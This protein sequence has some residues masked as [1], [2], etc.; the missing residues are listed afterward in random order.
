MQKV[1]SI[2]KIKKYIEK[3]KF[4][5]DPS[6]AKSYNKKIKSK[7]I[8]L[9]IVGTITPP[10]GRG[11]FYT[12]PSNKMYKRIDLAL[13]NGT[14]LENDVN[15]LGCLVEE[16]FDINS[17]RNRIKSIRNEDR[18]RIKKIEKQ[19]S[20]NEIYFLDVFESVIRKN[21]INA[22]D[23]FWYVTLDN[24]NFKDLKYVENVLI[25]SK[26]AYQRFKEIVNSCGDR[27][28]Y[29]NILCLPQLGRGFAKANRPNGKDMNEIWIDVIRHCLKG[30]DLCPE[31]KNLCVIEDLN[32]DW[33]SFR[34]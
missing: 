32:N 25:N 30:D 26:E 19:L 2:N 27:Q 24:K 6:Y 9:L 17:P 33:P 18:K 20:E 29:N 10:S 13:E 8:K 31:L 1:E 23:D 22:Q 16:E 4:E 5:G 34:N 3:N 7:K 21:R 12:S 28:K 11:Y 14:N 15:T